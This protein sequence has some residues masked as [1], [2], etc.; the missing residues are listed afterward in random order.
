MS[1]EPGSTTVTSI[2]QG[3]SSCRSDS[4][5]AS[6]ANF[7]V[8]YG[9]MKGLATRPPIEAMKTIVPFALRSSGMQAWVTAT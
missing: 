4:P 6:I 8:L 3:R 5:R 7:D 1:I 2:S 9:D